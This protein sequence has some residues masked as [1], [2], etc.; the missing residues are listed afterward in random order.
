VKIRVICGNISWRLLREDP[1]N[2]WQYFLKKRYIKLVDHL[3]YNK[4]TYAIIGSCMEV[5]RVL[6]NGFSEIVY[7]DALMYEATFRELP[8]DRE[9][10]FKVRYKDTIL[11]R[12]FFADFVFYDKII[13]EIKASEGAI[14]NNCISQVLN[15]LKASGCKIGLIVNFGGSSLEHK[16]LIF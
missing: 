12:S 3:I 11:P 16:R 7:K 10:E 6:G 8:I 1:G 2:P 5:H 15:Y 4:E 13:V 14:N 9:R